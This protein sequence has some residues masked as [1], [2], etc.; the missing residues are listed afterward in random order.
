MLDYG[1]TIFAELDYGTAQTLQ[2]Q[3]ATV[4]VSTCALCISLFVVDRIPRNICLSVGMF[5]VAIPLSIEAAM[6]KLYVGTT[7]KSG[8]SAGATMIYVYI[9]FYGIFLDGPGYFYVS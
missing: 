9:F 4:C 1:P 6:A 3:A 2:L 5:L 8:L 7:N